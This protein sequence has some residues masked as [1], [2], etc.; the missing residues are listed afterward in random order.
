VKRRRPSA[1]PP[2]LD[3]EAR[4]LGAERSPELELAFLF[5]IAA[6]AFLA[7]LA[8]DAYLLRLVAKPWPVIAL[9]RWVSLAR[10]RLGLVSAALYAGAVGD[11]LLELGEPTFMAGIV[12]FLVGHLLYVGGMLRDTRAPHLLRA[13]PPLVVF[14]VVVA[15]LGRQMG[16]GVI[17]F[18]TY[19][20]ALSVLVWRAAARI[21]APDVDRRLALVGTAGAASFMLSDCLIAV[22]RFLTDVPGARWVIIVTYWLGQAMLAASFALGSEP[23]PVLAPSA[24]LEGA[25]APAGSASAPY[26]AAHDLPAAPVDA[27]ARNDTGDEDRTEDDDR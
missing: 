14:G 10:P 7:G 15:F 13:L 24:S 16:A 27:A 18:A 4:I 8:T 5:G 17:P 22:D 3:A 2:Q 11:V 9:A 25:A 19:G 21:G 20:L 26:V 12:A 1:E 23:S 6:F